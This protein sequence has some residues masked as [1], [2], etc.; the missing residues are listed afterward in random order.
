MSRPYAEVIG[1]PIAQSKSPLIHNFWLERLGIDAEYRRCHVR[2]HELPEYFASRCADPAWR[3]CNV[4]IP[5][6]EAVG[7]F[8]D[9]LDP[10][11]K[12]VGAVN[13]VFRSDGL[14]TCGTNTDVDGVAEAVAGHALKGKKAV[15][16]GAGGAARSAFSFLSSAGCK[17]MVVA[18][19]VEKA[20]KVARDIELDADL[21]PLAPGSGALDNA[22][23]LINATQLGMTGQAPMPHY[24][25]DELKTMADGALVFDMVYAPLETDLL[26]AAADNGL[27][28]SGG[29][30]MLVGQAATAFEKFF[31]C[32]PPRDQDE[33]LLRIL[34]A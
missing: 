26:K 5:H 16:L 9:R 25:L 20:G 23:L 32:K 11:A 21:V 34:M 3:G 30:T 13:T 2:P 12:S 8:L 19:N 7:P 10:K 29:L 15:V 17:T 24:L 6:K 27:K 18:R 14:L 4:T 31:G 1:D 33:E 28:T 22:T